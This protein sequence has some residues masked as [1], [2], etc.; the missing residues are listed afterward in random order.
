VRLGLTYSG[1]GVDVLDRRLISERVYGEV[2]LVSFINQHYRSTIFKM[3]NS[4]VPTEA[5]CAKPNRLAKYTVLVRRNG[6]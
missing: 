1:D 4:V 2:S 3:A 6:E 5:I